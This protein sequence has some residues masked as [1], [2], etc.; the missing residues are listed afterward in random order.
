M[1]PP[2]VMARSRA[3]WEGLTGVSAE[4]A[5]ALQVA[6]SPGSR[7]CPPH[8]VGIV[9]I[10]DAVIATAPTAD[11]AKTVQQALGALP[12]SPLTDPQMLSTRLQLLQVLG[13]ACLAYL[14]PGEF[15]PCHGLIA[16]EQLHLHDEDLRQLVAA[17]G[18]EDV[19]E[20]GSTRSRHLHSPSG[21]TE[22]SSRSRATATGRAQSR[23][24]RF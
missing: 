10:A 17:C 7:L 13:P 12:A 16:V 14:D 2:T 11:A 6:V 18:A 8:W 1:Y 21:I 4:F 22:R 20:S 24:Y 9:V 19:H 15:R 23:T 5:P 3:L